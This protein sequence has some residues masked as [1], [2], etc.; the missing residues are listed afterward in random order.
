MA[1]RPRPVYVLPM[2]RRLL[3]LF[4]LATAARADF[5]PAWFYDPFWGD[6]KAEFLTYEGTLGR[7]GAAQPAE[8]IQIFVQENFAPDADVKADDWNRP[9]AFPVLKL[10]QIIHV[11]TGVYVYQQMH[12]AFWAQQ[13]GRLFKWS[14]T[15]NDSCGNTF[16]VATRPRS[17]G[18]DTWSYSFDTYWEGMVKGTVEVKDAPGGIFYDELP[19]RVRTID[20]SQ[21]KGSFEIMLAPSS[22][23]SKRGDFSFKKAIVSHQKEGDHFNV[24]IVHAQG[25]D[26]FVVE[27]KSPFRVR[28]WRGWDGSHL[29]LK[30]ALKLEYWKYNHPGDDERAAREGAIQ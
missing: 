17:T 18:S 22:I 29:T 30:R 3:P 25:K 14:M 10:N 13:S 15:S 7:Y 4:L 1:R 8:V 11:K 6:G 5:S 16:K 2:L 28:E 27:A 20:F 9:G 24:E 23:T 21:E 19:A 12:S 26:V